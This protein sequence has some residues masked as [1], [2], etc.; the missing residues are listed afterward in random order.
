[1]KIHVVFRVTK[2]LPHTCHLQITYPLSRTVHGCTGVTALQEGPP[3]TSAV[4]VLYSFGTETTA[5]Y[6]YGNAVQRV[7]PVCAVAYC[8]I[9]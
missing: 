3:L 8:T 9:L 5:L 7:Q 4:P 1:M 2:T 6:I